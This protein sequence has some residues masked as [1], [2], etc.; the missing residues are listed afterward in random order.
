MNAITPNISIQKTIET[1]TE[2]HRDFREKSLPEIEVLFENALKNDQ[3]T[4]S[5]IFLS[6]MFQNFKD[7]FIFHMK[8][9][10]DE[11]FKN[12]DSE[13]PQPHDDIPDN[14]LLAIEKSVGSLIRVNRNDLV[15]K[16]LHQ[17]IQKLQ[18]QLKTHSDIEERIFSH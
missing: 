12:L 5:I 8:I 18:Q 17:K 6:K 1:L 3:T 4:D 14:L 16:L 11:L 15:L 13:E 7:H 2:N 9:E 10:E